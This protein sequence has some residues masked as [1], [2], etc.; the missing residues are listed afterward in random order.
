MVTIAPALPVLEPAHTSRA[1]TRSHLQEDS[2]Q[3]YQPLQFS[4]TFT[5]SDAPS[6]RLSQKDV[7]LQEQLFYRFLALLRLRMN[8]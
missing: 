2:R 5:D 3:D 7:F 1:T 6:Q 8:H 4:V